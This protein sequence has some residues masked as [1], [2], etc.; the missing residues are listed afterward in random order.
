[1]IRR[2]RK[3]DIDEINRLLFQ[4]HKV[5]SDIRQ[6]L[7]IPGKKKY[8]SEEL[9]KIIDDDSTPVFVYED[10]GAICGYLFGIFTDTFKHDS[11]VD[12]RSLYIDD[13]CVDENKRS[14]GIGK[15]L[16]SFIKDF[17]KKNGCYNITLNV[18]Q[19]NDSSLAFYQKLGMK[20]QKTVME[21][22]L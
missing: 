2:A 12:H 3:S 13:L 19:G 5:H 17:A 20:V 21:E 22:I 15:A 18:W 1:M 4:V 16:Y 11:L 8:S 7:F 6:D 9:E 14:K 10:E